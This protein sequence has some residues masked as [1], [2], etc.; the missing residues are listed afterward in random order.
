MGLYSVRQR[1]SEIAIIGKP[2]DPSH[3]VESQENIISNMKVSMN[4]LYHG[5]REI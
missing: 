4:K 3:E 2:Y 1:G 5:Q